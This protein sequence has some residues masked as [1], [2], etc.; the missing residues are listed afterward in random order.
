MRAAVVAGLLLVAGSVALQ[1]LQPSRARLCSLEELAPAAGRGVLLAVLGGY[2]AVA[3]DALWLR[4]NLA[5]EARDAVATEAL[6]RATVAADDRAEYFRINGARI[7]AFDLPAW[8]IGS[9]LPAAVAAAIRR[10]HAERAIAFLQAGNMR[11]G[12]RAAYWI[13]MGRIA[14]QALHDR[15][16]AADY[17]G[18]AAALADAPYFAGRLRAE[19]LIAEGRLQEARDWLRHWLPRLP[20]DDPAAQVERVA[21]RLAEL[22]RRLGPP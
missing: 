16:R 13:E 6:I 4:T 5:W 1:P 11:Q 22:E 14:D 3:A 8:R 17:Y 18:R 2:R 9:E 19:L 7:I 10:E 21:A 12:P 15:R 20:R